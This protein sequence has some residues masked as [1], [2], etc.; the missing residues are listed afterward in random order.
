VIDDQPQFPRLFRDRVHGD[1]DHPW[2]ERIGCRGKGRRET[3]KAFLFALR[4]GKIERTRR[5]RTLWKI[6]RWRVQVQDFVSWGP[7]TFLQTCDDRFDKRAIGM[8]CE[9]TLEPNNV[10]RGDNGEK[11][12]I[13]AKREKG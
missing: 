6:S 3:P 8:R 5:E 12:M 7:E 2:Q 4:T 11:V 10:D 1:V 9:E 13:F